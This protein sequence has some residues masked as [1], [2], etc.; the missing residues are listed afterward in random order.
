MRYQSIQNMT[1][2]H[3]TKC[4]FFQVSTNIKIH[5]PPILVHQILM[6]NH[7]FLNEISAVV[8]ARPL[9]SVLTFL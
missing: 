6:K 4:Q 7:V 9:K 5:I 8:L 1:E 3:T 2:F